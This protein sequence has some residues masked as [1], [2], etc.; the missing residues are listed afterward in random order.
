MI[1]TSAEWV[2]NWL[3]WTEWPFHLS[4][5]NVEKRVCHDDFE[6]DK[7]EFL[8]SSSFY[9]DWVQLSCAC[10]QVYNTKSSTSPC[11]EETVLYPNNGGNQYSC[12]KCFHWPYRLTPR[13][14]GAEQDVPLEVSYVADLGGDWVERW[15][16]CIVLQPMTI[17]VTPEEN[18]KSEW[19]AIVV[20]WNVER[21]A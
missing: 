15:N 2:W 13:C 17:A 10:S 21:N 6:N 18:V 9:L 14:C 5:R 11:Q 1:R 7:H 12:R 8:A 4:A 3:S 20:K 19:N 16:L